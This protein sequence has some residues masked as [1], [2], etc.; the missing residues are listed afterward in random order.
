MD[1]K[2]IEKAYREIPNFIIKLGQIFYDAV[3][4]D[5]NFTS[6]MAK[7]ILQ[8]F[9]KCETEKDFEIADGMLIAICGYSFETLLQKIKEKD[10]EGFQW[11]WL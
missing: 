9:Y 7:S 2:I 11:E 1:G 8:V 4:E 5:D 3:Q 6:D 10:E